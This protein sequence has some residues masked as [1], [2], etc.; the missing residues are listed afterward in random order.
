M[1][2]LNFRFNDITFLCNEN[3][4]IYKKIPAIPGF[5]PKQGQTWSVF[6]LRTQPLDQT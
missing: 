1:I 4:I 3:K 2:L 5:Q 6:G